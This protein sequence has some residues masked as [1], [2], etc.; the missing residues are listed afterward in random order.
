MTRQPPA[1]RVA[2]P[3]PVFPANAVCPETANPP[4]L[5]PDLP[6]ETKMQIAQAVAGLLRRMQRG[7]APAGKENGRVDRVACR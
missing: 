5:W 2:S 4:R 7:P 3:V 6:V 1:L